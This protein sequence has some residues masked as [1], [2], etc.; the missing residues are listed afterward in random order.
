MDLELLFLHRYVH[1]GRFI[2]IFIS[3]YKVNHYIILHKVIFLGYTI[4]AEYSNTEPSL[5]LAFHHSIPTSRKPRHIPQRP[6]SW[7]PFQ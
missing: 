7:I 4:F 2:D 1:H 3:M 6:N 5:L